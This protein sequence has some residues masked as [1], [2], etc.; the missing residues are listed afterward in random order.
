MSVTPQEGSKQEKLPSKLIAWVGRTRQRLQRPLVVYKVM[1]PPHRRIF[2]RRVRVGLFRAATV[3]GLILLMALPHAQL[4]AFP[5]QCSARTEDVY[6][7]AGICFEAASKS[8]S[9]YQEIFGFEEYLA[10]LALFVVLYTIAEF[11]FKFRISVA[12]APLRRNTFWILIAIGVA[13]IV[14]ETA[15]AESWPLPRACMFFNR[16]T[17]QL[18]L[19]LIFFL[20]LLTWIYYAFIR[21]PRF[22][23]RN[24]LPFYSEVYFI[25]R[26]GNEQELAQL[27]DE[28]ARSAREIVELAAE[29][30]H[31][32]SIDEASIA[33]RLAND[34]LLIIADRKF[35]QQIVRSSPGTAYAFFSALNHSTG[36][37][38]RAI[39]PFAQ[40]ISAEAMLHHESFVYQETEPFPT[41]GLAQIY[42]VTSVL[43]GNYSA[44]FDLG[45][46]S[47][48]ELR[49]DEFTRWRASKWGAYCRVTLIFIRSYLRT[50]L[51]FHPSPIGGALR[52]LELAMFEIGKAESYSG[53]AQSEGGQRLDAMVDLVEGALREIDEAGVLPELLDGQG[54]RV[55]DDLADLAADLVMHVGR[56]DG[57][58]YFLWNIHHNMI[59]SQLVERF[60]SD[61]PTHRAFRAR[62]FRVL[63]SEISRLKTFPNYKGAPMLGFLLHVLN[64]SGEIPKKGNYRAE[65]RQLTLWVRRWARKNFWAIH[66]ADK[67]VANAAMIG[68]LSL[69]VETRR[70]VYTHQSRLPMKA[71]IYDLPLDA[72]GSSAEPEIPQKRSSPYR[73]QWRKRRSLG[74]RYV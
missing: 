49:Y 12:P 18:A 65:A 71:V 68:P 70:I 17:F 21:P 28:L 34:T 16:H 27:G 72:D 35:C 44:I 4:P 55:L 43:Y 69:D 15:A 47:P 60:T 20:T 2:W 38:P 5:F 53:G 14:A 39:G 37:V 40:S 52:H 66:L 61:T 19:G 29:V 56:I 57:A 25:L 32:A 11:R 31:V 59:W 58:Q 48:L 33:A 50:A 46:Y 36:V 22:G 63:R 9:A 24:A 74:R 64:V 54:K 3:A 45:H 51:G 42:P 23:H 73:P 30:R 6:C 41:G 8:Q 10:A 1:R 26:R 62:F 13:A 7:I 67:D